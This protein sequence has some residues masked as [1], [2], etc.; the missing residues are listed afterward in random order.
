M[1]GS[2]RLDAGLSAT[3]IGECVALA[4]SAED[5]VDFIGDAWDD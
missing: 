1:A 5:M 2:D 3:R 4:R